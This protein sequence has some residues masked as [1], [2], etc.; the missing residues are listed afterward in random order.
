MC[1][2]GPFL[3]IAHVCLDKIVSSFDFYVHEYGCMN[4]R[5]LNVL[6][7]RF[8]YIYVYAHI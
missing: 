5:D 7:E 1:F 6:C 3:F 2:M 4:M 8:A